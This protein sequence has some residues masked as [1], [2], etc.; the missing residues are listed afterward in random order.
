MFFAWQAVMKWLWRIHYWPVGLSLQERLMLSWLVETKADD[1]AWHLSILGFRS[2]S[3]LSALCIFAQCAADPASSDIQHI[4]HPTRERVLLP[5]F[6]RKLCVFYFRFF[7]F[8]SYSIFQNFQKLHCSYTVSFSCLAPLLLAG[9][10]AIVRLHF[11]QV[12]DG[13]SDLCFPLF[14]IPGM[15][16][17]EDPC[18]TWWPSRS[19]WVNPMRC[20]GVSCEDCEL[21]G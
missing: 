17:E 21:W 3:N 20:K 4:Q 16:G 14:S 15:R 19:N 9:K 2:E 10:P 1:D 8:G 12:Q 6:G 13:L 18:Q 7:L 5:R 11:T